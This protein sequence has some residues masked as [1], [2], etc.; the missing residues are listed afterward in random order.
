MDDLPPNALGRRPKQQR[1][2][3][4]IDAV[5]ATAETLIAAQGLSALTIPALA[6]QLGFSRMSI[7]HFFPTPQAIINKLGQRHWAQMQKCVVA[8]VLARPQQQWREQLAI[9]VQVLAGYFDRYP[10][11]RAVVLDG[12]LTDEG[13]QAHATTVRKL[14]DLTAQFLEANGVR[15]PRKPIDVTSLAVELG[16]TTFRVSVQLHGCVTAE[17]QEEAFNV[18]AGYLGPHIARASHEA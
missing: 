11:A 5:L 17:F 13:Y 8:E 18:V 4:R 16:V 2:Q 14:G 6:E 12:T 7:Y 3:A 15:L 1:G 9:V 10:T